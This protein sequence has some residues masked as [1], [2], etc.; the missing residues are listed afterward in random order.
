VEGFTREF[1]FDSMSEKGR[2]EDIV[3]SNEKV[4]VEKNLERNGE[5]NYQGFSHGNSDTIWQC[6]E[7]KK[8]KYSWKT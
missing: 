1:G 4:G 7:R 6:Y 5:E 8:I 3:E 2:E